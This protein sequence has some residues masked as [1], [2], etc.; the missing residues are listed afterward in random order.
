MA[1]VTDATDVTEPAGL[2]DALRA[3]PKVELHCHVEGTMRPGTVAPLGSAR[4]NPIRPT[5]TI[6]ALCMSTDE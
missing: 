1:A 4:R 3:L 2:A 5:S 6:R